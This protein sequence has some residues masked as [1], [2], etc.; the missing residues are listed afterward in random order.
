MRCAREQSKPF[1]STYR[2]PHVGAWPAPVYPLYICCLFSRMS[3]AVFPYELYSL[4][5]LLEQI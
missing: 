1:C 5:V 2:S 4:F 3:R